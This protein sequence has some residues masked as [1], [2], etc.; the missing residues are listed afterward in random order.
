MLAL[1]LALL[2]ALPPAIPD[3]RLGSSPWALVQLRSEEAVPPAQGYVVVVPAEADR[4]WLARLVE[5]ASRAPVVG[6]GGA[7]P[8]S[9]VQ[10]LDGVVVASSEEAEAVRR[11][12]P[13]VTLVAEAAGPAEA[14]AKL[15]WGVTSFLVPGEP[16]WVEAVAGAFADPQPATVGDE[17]LP[18]AE[19]PSDLS[20]LVGIPPGFPGGAVV[21]PTTW[22]AATAELV[23]GEGTQ[24]LAVQ[25][26]GES[27]QVSVP[28]LP[29]GGLLVVPRPLP[30]GGLQRVE[31][32]A[33]RDLTLGEVLARHHRQVAGQKRLVRTF[34]AWQRLVVRVRIQELDRS[35]ELELA[36]PAFEAGDTGR[37]WELREARV[38]GAPWPVE[39]LPE[40][41]LVQPK[42]PP[43]PPLALE[44]E[45]SYRYRLVG[46]SRWEGR[47]VYVLGFSQQ[48]GEERRWG[49]AYLDA[50]TFGLVALESWQETPEQDVRRSRTLTR[51][52]FF[53][54]DGVP[55]WLP[56]RV[57]GDDTVAT[58]GSVV[59]VHRELTLEEPQ[60]NDP[61]FRDRWAD[62]WR[63]PRPMLR[64]RRGEMVFLE[65]DGTGGRR[66]AAGGRKRQS[67]LLAG[68]YW[69]P[70]LDHPLPLVGYQFLDM[71]FR[72]DQQL[73]LFLAGAVN[74]AAWSRPGTWETKAS[75]FLQLIPFTANLWQRDRERESEEVYLFRQKLRAGVSRH[76]GSFRLTAEAG[77]DFLHFSRTSET[78]PAFR[79][80]VSTP[81]TLV[82]L[83]LVWHQ[84]QFLAGARWERGERLSWRRWGFGE[85]PEPRFWRG[86]VFGRYERRF[87]P[88]A[89]VS[90]AADLATSRHTDRFS[91]FSLGG[92]GGGFFGVPGG[93]VKAEE[94]AKLE[95]AVAWPWGSHRVELA[96]HAG[97]VRNRQW[98]QN[99]APVSSLR[100]GVN[101]RGP[102]GTV[103]QASLGW[104]LVVPG[105]N[106]PVVQ[107]VLLRPWR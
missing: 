52:R 73:R 5:L 98:G 33:K 80:P 32:T 9:V 106:A 4:E 28:A 24:A 3:P 90:L 104:P 88:L 70:G 63:G 89:K 40:L 101:R 84:G 22:V 107:V 78:D 34:S 60:L 77:A 65:P 62:A 95:A 81:E 39:E 1:G 8:E 74:E 44:L 100:V 36:G 67:F 41:P 66:E 56:W 42:A 13:G 11:C 71:G 23:A 72:G 7:A 38:D 68:T 91:Q 27:A 50:A 102:W 96:A 14:L 57:E 64:E 46:S 6:V 86:G 54:L 53:E 30:P 12:C 103:L 97:W 20:L 47:P 15:P 49:R 85:K 61:A 83:E 37:D 94:L 17:A 87:G 79:L 93:R 45:P 75:L 10:Y 18:T 99:A 55:L 2:T 35:V 59:T 29:S 51:N 16:A 105:P 19:K 76:W 26:K 25:V 21:L 31:V 82:G 92:F 58:F 69:D 48:R 43:V